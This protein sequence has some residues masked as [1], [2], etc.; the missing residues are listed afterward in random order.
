[1]STLPKSPVGV[2]SISLRNQVR[3]KL[4][5]AI[6]SGDHCGY[7]HFC[8]KNEPQCGTRTVLGPEICSL[9]FSSMWNSCEFAKYRWTTASD[10]PPWV[11]RWCFWDEH[12]TGKNQ[13]A[14]GVSSGVCRAHSILLPPHLPPP[15]PSSAEVGTGTQS[16]FIPITAACQVFCCLFWCFPHLFRQSGICT[17]CLKRKQ[18]IDTCLKCLKFKVCFVLEQGR[19]TTR[20]HIATPAAFSQK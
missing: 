7:G 17:V 9:F 3:E 2:L 8:L 12:R 15:P 19:E 1:M 11:W 6:L 18:K 13:A 10:I 5:I 4:V 14:G 20:Y 16:I